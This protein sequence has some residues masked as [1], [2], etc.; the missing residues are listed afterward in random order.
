MCRDK[1]PCDWYLTDDAWAKFAKEKYECRPVSKRK[2]ATI[3]AISDLIVSSSMGN[4]RTTGNA[5]GG[6]PPTCTKLNK[7]DKA[8]GRASSTG[9][10][11]LAE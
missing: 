6:F 5:F 1:E 9:Y 10:S 11:E 7:E 4:V 2:E 8:M 3:T